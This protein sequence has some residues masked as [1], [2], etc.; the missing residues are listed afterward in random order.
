[1]TTTSLPVFVVDDDA[2]VLRSITRLLLSADYRV[3]AFHS[4]QEFIDSSKH[5]DA[6]IR[7]S[8]SSASTGSQG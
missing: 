7:R 8:R 3:M 5:A 2:S 1:M 6:K 4:P